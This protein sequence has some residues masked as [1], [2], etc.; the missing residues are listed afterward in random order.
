[1][2]PEGQG[3]LW[4]N[5]AAG[6]RARSW[7]DPPT[8]SPDPSCEVQEQMADQHQLSRELR[9]GMEGEDISTEMET[10]TLLG[11]IQ[12]WGALQPELSERCVA[13]LLF[14]RHFW[15]IMLDG[16][17]D[18]QIFSSVLKNRQKT[19]NKSLPESLFFLASPKVTPFLEGNYGNKKDG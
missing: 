17:R 15:H 12:Q 6:G 16:V 7:G 3:Q 9:Q 18:T 8:Y 4:V 11:E 14:S 2:C 13:V 19:N 5:R 1:M 10:G